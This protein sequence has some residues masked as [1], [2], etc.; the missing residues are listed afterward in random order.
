MSDDFDLTQEAMK[1]RERIEAAFSP[2]ESLK[3]QSCRP[4]LAIVTAANA[5]KFSQAPKKRGR[6]PKT[7]TGGN[8]VAFRRPEPVAPPS[9]SAD[10]R[11]RDEVCRRFSKFVDALERMSAKRAAKRAEREGGQ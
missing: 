1:L 9:G 5:H 3:P 10:E 8:V 2:R 4:A 7:Q 11:A 6:K